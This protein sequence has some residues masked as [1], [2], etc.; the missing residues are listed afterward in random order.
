MS[1][2]SNSAQRKV[3]NVGGSTKL[4]PIPDRYTGWVHHLLD[5]DARRGAD[6]VC[7]ARKLGELAQSTYDAVY[8]SHN[9]EHYYAHHVP[10]VLLGFHHVLKPD[11]FVELRVPDLL[12]VMELVVA[13]KLELDEKLYDSPAGPISV[14]D[15]IYG[16]GK[17]IEE[18]GLDFFSH[19][20]GFSPKLL[21]RLLGQSGFE[22]AIIMRGNNLELVAYGFKLEPPPARLIELGLPIPRAPGQ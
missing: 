3:L 8:C 14:R 20:T 21:L 7:D 6:I 9:L 15:V 19:K 11:G 10:I 16:W 5:I 22:H 18:S 12:M 2:T 4:I 17:E 13:K 1:E